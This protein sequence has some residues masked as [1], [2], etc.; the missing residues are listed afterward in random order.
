MT[1]ADRREKNIAIFEDTIEMCLTHP[2]LMMSVKASVETQELT[3]EET[4]FVYEDDML[5]TRDARA[6]V[7]ISEK[8]SLAAAQPYAME[9]K[10]V[11]VLNFAAWTTPGG[12]VCCGSS[13]QEESLCRCST[14]YPCIS[15]DSVREEFYEP[16][17]AK[18][19]VDPKYMLHNDDLIYTPDVTVFKSDTSM[20]ELLPS[21]EWYKVDVITC[22]APKLKLSSMDKEHLGVSDDLLSIGEDELKDIF[23]SRITKILTV[24][25]AHDVDVVIL[26]AFGCGAF[27]NPPALVAQVFNEVIEEFIYS[28]DVIEFPIFHVGNEDENYNAFCKYITA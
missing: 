2:V 19:K 10:R 28:F 26:G 20:P 16:H 4:F 11:A 21:E 6:R 9:G 27:K 24:A 7:V 8:R 17:K 5:I 3:D 15:E 23:R 18:R 13:A 12:G 25:L 22:A 1:V 14:L